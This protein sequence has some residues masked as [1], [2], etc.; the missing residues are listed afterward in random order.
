M[1]SLTHIKRKNKR[2][3]Y[4]EARIRVEETVRHVRMFQRYTSFEY[5][6]PRPP[7]VRTISLPPLHLSP[8]VSMPTNCYTAEGTTRTSFLLPTKRS[9]VSAFR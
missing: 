6:E 7:R 9:A 5:L 3:S 4:A 2:V 8:A 1:G